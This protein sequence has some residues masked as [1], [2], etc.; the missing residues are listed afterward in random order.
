MPSEIQVI[1][2]NDE[3]INI[4]IYTNNDIIHKII[5]KPSNHEIYSNYLSIFGKSYIIGFTYSLSQNYTSSINVVDYN[6]T[7]IE[8]TYISF[9]QNIITIHI[10]LYN[11]MKILIFLKIFAKLMMLLKT[12]IL[13]NIN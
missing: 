5:S 1:P 8:I 11:L 2:C 4:S 9:R 12:I 3:I 7:H 13:K 10:I 6:K